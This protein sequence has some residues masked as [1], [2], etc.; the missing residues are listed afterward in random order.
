MNHSLLKLMVDAAREEGNG[1][2]EEGR[3]SRP[4]VSGTHLHLNAR[5]RFLFR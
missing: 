4:E 3:D 1:R 2:H 5:S